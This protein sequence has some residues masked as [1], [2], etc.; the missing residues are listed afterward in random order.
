MR[1]LLARFP[2]YCCRQKD[3]IS[4]LH[5]EGLPEFEPHVFVVVGY[6]HCSQE[7]R[8]VAAGKELSQQNP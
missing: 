6:V 8:E 7:F 1:F 3:L 5:S 2:D 4:A